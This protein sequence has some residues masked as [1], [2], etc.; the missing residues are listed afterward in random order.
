MND[1]KIS[2]DRFDPWL[3]TQAFVHIVYSTRQRIV[4]GKLFNSRFI[5]IG[6]PSCEDS[7]T[8]T[9]AEKDK[10]LADQDQ[11]FDYQTG[12]CFYQD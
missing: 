5:V 10:R 4:L 11:I 12:D 7:E 9:R 3:L 1:G 6:T 2:W 8:R